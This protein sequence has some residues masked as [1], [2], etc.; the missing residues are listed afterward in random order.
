MVSRRWAS[1]QREHY[2]DDFRRVYVIL[3]EENRTEERMEGYGK[4][5]KDDKYVV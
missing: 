1:W 4:D 3:A 2:L 5:E